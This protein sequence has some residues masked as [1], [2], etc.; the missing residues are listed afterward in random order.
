MR[1]VQRERRYICGKSKAKAERQDVEIYTYNPASQES[2]AADQAMRHPPKFKG[3]PPAQAKHNA[4][5]ARRFFLR[6]LDTNF[7]EKDTHTALT[8]ADENLPENEDQAERDIN[9]FLRHL[10]RE[11]KKQ[12]LPGPEALVVTEWQDE[13]KETG[14]KA[15]RFHHH[16]VLHCDLTRDEIE[17]CWHR[18]G[19]R[20]GYANADRLR[21]DK[22]SLE[23]LAAYLMKYTNRKHRYKRTRGIRDPITPPANDNKYT[24]RQIERICKDPAKLYSAEF[25]RRKYPGW[26]LTEAVA[27]YNEFLGWAISLKMHRERRRE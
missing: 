10:R 5:A 15:V 16:V 6:L 9:N 7:T 20:L 27:T 12:G 3:T 21:K 25:W 14:R 13:D 24:R 11:C 2:R 18:N 1:A 23:A 26:T 4:K 22:K 17:A 8:Y 19:K